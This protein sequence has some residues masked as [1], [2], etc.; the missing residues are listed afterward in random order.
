MWNILAFLSLLLM[1]GVSG[2]ETD[3]TEP[4]S[5]MEGDSVT[6]HTNLSEIQNDD[7]ILWM[8]GPKDF[9]LS[10]VK[11]KNDFTSFSVTDDVEFRGRLQ[12]DQK[13]GSLTIRNTRL[14]HSGQYKLTIS[15]QKITTKIFNVTVSDV[16]IETDG[17]KSVSVS[18]TE[19]EPATLPNDA[20]MNK[21]ALMLW[22]FGDKGLLLAKL[23]VET[24]E[25]SL[26]EADGTFRGRLK[27]DHQTGSLTITNTRTEDSGLYELQ[28][29]GTESSRQFL[30]SVTDVTSLSTGVVAGIVIG[31]LVP[32][33]LLLAAAFALKNYRHKISKLEEKMA[34]KGE[35]KEETVTEGNNFTLRTDLTEIQGNDMIEWCYEAEN[36]LIAE[37]KTRRPSTMEGADGRFRSKLRLEENNGDLTISNI[38]T[39]HSGLYILKINNSIRTKYIL[40]VKVSSVSVE[41]GRPVLLQT[42][43]KINTDDLVLWTLGAKNCLVVKTDSRATDFGE[44]FRDRVD[45]NKQTGSLT[46]R[47]ITTNDAGHYKLQVINNEQAT[48]RRFNVTVTDSSANQENKDVTVVTPLLNDDPDGGN[49]QQATSSV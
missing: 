29:R 32:L 24:N 15:R 42:G 27:L 14:R 36:N 21:D 35:K 17:V 5:V 33:L 10:Q 48:F 3:E 22:R 9:P 28:I 46:I 26:T 43:A 16:V 44:R 18:V 20:K 6:L 40:T 2:S 23:D 41:A 25:T 34:V 13:T 12:V 38:R 19:G 45:L 11:R 47:N 4:V 7:T 30:L 37:I 39:I 31:L 49:E 8:F 1:Y